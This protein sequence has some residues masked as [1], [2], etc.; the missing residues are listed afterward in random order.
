MCEL[1]TSLKRNLNYSNDWVNAGLMWMKPRAGTFEFINDVLETITLFNLLDQDA[2]Q[3]VLTEHS[4][5]VRPRVSRSTRRNLF[6]INSKV[7]TSHYN[8]NWEFMPHSTFTNAAFWKT[9]PACVKL[10]V[11]VVTVHSNCNTK[12]SYLRQLH[13][14]MYGD[15][16]EVV[17]VKDDRLICIGG[18]DFVTFGKTKCLPKV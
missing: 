14:C 18:K 17:S 7:R 10:R 3:M 16:N 1:K 13:R 2:I 12:L 5:V 11:G 15:V 8:Y 4:Q 6:R 9:P